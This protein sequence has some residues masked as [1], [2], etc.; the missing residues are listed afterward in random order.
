VRRLALLALL[1]VG[2]LLVAGCGSDEDE[3]TSE[4]AAAPASSEP[5]PS[6]SELAL[7][8]S[9]TEPEFSATAPEAGTQTVAPTSPQ[10][11][12][13]ELAIT[14]WELGKDGGPPKDYTL[15]CDP[16]GGT[17]PEPEAACTALAAGSVQFDPVPPDT[18]C[19]MIYGGTAVAEVKGTVLGEPVD[20]EFS[21]QD[22][23]QIDRWT[24]ATALLPADLDAGLGG[25]MFDSTS[26]QR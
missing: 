7:G 3:A 13:T 22:G 17:L 10:T 24:S 25:D 26:T 5:A 11:G 12:A 16:A 6:S 23:C 1:L 18:A 9:V 21:R 4:S 15:T 19:T 20:A 14:V 2:A 8:E